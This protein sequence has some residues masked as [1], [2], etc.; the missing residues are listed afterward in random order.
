MLFHFE[1]RCEDRWVAIGS[2]EGT[3]EEAR[4]AAFADLIA[5]AGGDL[6]PGA[7]RCILATSAAAHWDPLRLGDDGEIGFAEDDAVILGLI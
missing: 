5:L 2:S 7:Y 1:F 4:L 6:R 3:G